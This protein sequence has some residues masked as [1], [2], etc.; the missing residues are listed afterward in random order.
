MSGLTPDQAWMDPGPVR[1]PDRDPVEYQDDA[2]ARG[3]LGPELRRRPDRGVDGRVS[4]A[5]QCRA[6]RRVQVDVLATIDVPEAG[7]LA[8]SR[9][10]GAT[11]RGVQACG[12]GHAA[13][14]PSR[15]RRIQ[16]IRPH[17]PG[18]HAAHGRD[19]LVGPLTGCCP[20]YICD[21]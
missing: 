20:I 18:L 15:S 16:L 14:E 13:D 12:G 2:V 5:E 6:E 7:A 19:P 21:M 1:N 4:V 3:H 17:R 8:A 10:E 11:E 9:V